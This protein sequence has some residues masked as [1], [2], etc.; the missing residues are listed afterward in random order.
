MYPF[1]ERESADLEKIAE[2]LEDTNIMVLS[3]EIYSEL[4]YN[5]EKHTSIIEIGDMAKRTI[6]VNGFSKAYSMTGWRLG[7]ICGPKPL[8]AQMLR[9]NVCADRFAVRGYRSD[10][11]LR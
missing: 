6:Y 9:D 2:V 7:Y 10:T 4:T 3:D 1:A 11:L 8:I 5:N